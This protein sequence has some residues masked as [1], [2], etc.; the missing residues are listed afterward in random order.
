MVGDALWVEKRATDVSTFGGQGARGDDRQWRL[1]LHIDDI[2][3]YTRTR[4]EHLEKIKEVLERLEAAGLRISLEK[5]EWVRG[6]VRYLGYVIGAGV[7]KMD[8]EKVD[9]ISK[10][11]LPAE[12]KV[13]GHYRP[14]LRKQIRRFLGAAGFYRRFAKDFAALTAPLTELTKTTERIAW[15]NEHTEAWKELQ[16]RMASYPILRQPNSTKEHFVDTDASNVGLGA[17]LMQRSEDGTPHPVAYASRKLTPAEQTY[18]TREQEAL[19]S[20]RSRSLIV[21]WPG[22]DLRQ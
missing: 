18:S 9:A 3:I 5:L 4:E 7:L 22:D 15:K 13:D 21:F 6:E 19:S 20:S 8:S 14:N 10:I 12:T 1:C 16:E 17:A 11:V 2:L